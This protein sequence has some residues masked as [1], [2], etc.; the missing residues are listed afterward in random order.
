[1][2][3]HIFLDKCN[4][5]FKNSKANVGLNPIA[6]LN[7]GDGISRILIHF[8]TEELEQMLEE[9]QFS[10]DEKFTA[11]LKM[12]NCSNIDGIPYDKKLSNPSNCGVKERAS[13]FT[14]L[15]IKLPEDFDEGRGFEHGGEP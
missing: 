15:A 11:H 12:T 7:Y 8:N 6:E 2:V 13:S 5:I 14:V 1:M 4:T 9:K 10:L 3:R